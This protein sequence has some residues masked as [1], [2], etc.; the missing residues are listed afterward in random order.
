MPKYTFEMNQYIAS[1]EETKWL[2]L[3]SFFYSIPAINTLYKKQYINTYVLILTSLASA[4][5]WRKATYSWRRTMDLAISKISF[6]SFFIQGITYVKYRPYI[7]IGYILL[8]FTIRFYYLSNK[9]YKLKNHTWYKYHF[10]FHMMTI[11]K[12]F[13]IINSIQTK[14]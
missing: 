2:V 10:L 5:F 1:W 7:I 11:L 8:F 4:N 14:K 12:I 13:L 6:L 9:Y 3:S